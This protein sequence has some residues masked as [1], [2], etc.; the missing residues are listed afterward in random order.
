MIKGTKR[1][2]IQ[3]IEASFHD[4][5][6]HQFFSDIAIEVFPCRT[7][8]Q[9]CKS[10]AAG[11][12]DFGLMAIE[13]SLVGSILPNYNLLGK[14]PLQVTGETYLHIEQ[15]LM[16][17]PGQKLQ[18]IHSVRS[19][20]MALHQCSEFLEKHPSIRGVET[21]DTAESARDVQ[22]QQLSGV[23]AIASRKA[24]SRYGLEILASEIENLKQNYTRFL[25]IEHGQAESI[26][27]NKASIS[28]RV[29]H[30]VGSLAQTLTVL[31]N[32]QI[33]LTK[34]QSIP[35]P[36]VMNEYAFHVDLLFSDEKNFK[37]AI[38]DLRPATRTLHLLGTYTQGQV[39]L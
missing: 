33:N 8:E 9:L 26:T 24:A 35:V 17:L 12:C 4:M 14:Y 25:V 16:A 38:T 6:A 19:H 3:G 30:Q 11:D 2:A 13:N 37:A 31:Q 32:R 18:D 5:A 39:V 7:F 10:V 29:K 1:I 23:A 15:N 34:I 22:Q 36:G 27:G 28:F 20:P 21:F